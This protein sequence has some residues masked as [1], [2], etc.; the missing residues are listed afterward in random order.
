MTQFDNSLARLT[1]QKV[2]HPEAVQLVDQ[3]VIERVKNIKY[4]DGGQEI[5]KQRNNKKQISFRIKHASIVLAAKRS[6]NLN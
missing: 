5:K 6:K 1:D 4:Q 2:S 3:R